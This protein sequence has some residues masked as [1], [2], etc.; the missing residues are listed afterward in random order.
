MNDYAS[1]IS[2]AEVAD[3]ENF[4]KRMDILHEFL[5]DYNSKVNLTRITGYEDYILKHVCDSLLLGVAFK[6]LTRRP[7]SIC[8][9][10]CGAGFPSLVL[11]AAYPGWEI[12]AVDSIGKK[13]TFVKLAAEKLQMANIEVVTGRT[14]ELNRKADW[15]KRFDIVTARAVAAARTVYTDARNFPKD[16]GRFILYKTPEQLK[17]D[18]PEIQNT[19]PKRKWQLSEIF[20]LPGNTGKRQFLYY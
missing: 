12:T 9:I 15:K 19:A 8:D 14:N 3:H 6:E 11:A 20:E 13:T 5:V 4:K 17:E 1:I 2:A 18:F 10:G 16:S 7:L